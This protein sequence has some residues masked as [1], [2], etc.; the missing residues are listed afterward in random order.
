[1]FALE[2]TYEAE[3]I[4]GVVL[5]DSGVKRGANRDNQI[6][7]VANH[8][9]GEAEHG[10]IQQLALALERLSETEHNQPHEYNQENE[11]ARIE[12]QVNVIDKEHLE[13]ACQRGQARND[14][15][16]G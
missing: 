8:N 6:R 15:Y 11:Q 4:F 3:H 9:K 1:M 12:G 2:V 16:Q 7:G 13:A 5:V 10:C 14:A